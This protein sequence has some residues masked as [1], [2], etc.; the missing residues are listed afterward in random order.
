MDEQGA[1]DF[2]AQIA[3]EK[4]AGVHE[5]PLPQGLKTRSFLSDGTEIVPDMA[6]IIVKQDGSVRTA[7]PYNS[8][9]DSGVGK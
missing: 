9:F 4:G 8:L 5:V 1:A 6:R 7:F 2:I 3:K